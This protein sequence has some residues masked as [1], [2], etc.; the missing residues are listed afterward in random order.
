LTA[1]V[2]DTNVLCV[3]DGSAP[4]ADDTCV[5][6]CVDFL[7]AARAGLILVDDVGRII[8]EYARN[9]SSGQ[10]GPG[11]LFLRWLWQNIANQQVC[12]QVTITPTSTSPE[13]FAEFPSD[14]DLAQFD[15]SDRK[16]VAVALAAGR[17]GTVV[18]AVDSDW[19]HAE[20]ALVR[21]RV[22]LRFLCPQH[23]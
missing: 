21:N 10:P 6:A 17:K 18:N 14:P 2:V 19:R 1:W 20:K 22:K 4:H 23:V 3:A 9:Q 15:L 16:F 7:E 5:I 12:E 11:T 13:E 8:D